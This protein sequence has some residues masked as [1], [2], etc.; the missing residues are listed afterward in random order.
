MGLED[1]ILYEME[2]FLWK[3]K[4][5]WQCQGSMGLCHVG[6]AWIAWGQMWFDLIMDTEEN[7]IHKL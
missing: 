6:D 4:I 2:I 1:C 3:R 7:A 5:A